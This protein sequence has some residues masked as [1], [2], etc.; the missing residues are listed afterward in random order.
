MCIQWEVELEN[1]KKTLEDMFISAD[2]DSDGI[3]TYDEFSALVWSIKPET[4]GREM[5]RLYQDALA[6]SGNTDSLTPE[7]FVKVASDH[8]LLSH[9]LQSKEFTSLSRGDD[10]WWVAS[11]S[12]W[13]SNVQR[14]NLSSD[15]PS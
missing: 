8:G 10:F 4:S 14:G 12:Q 1:T 2:V 6:N 15:E 11:G 13:S 5:T 3:L 7:G 9:M